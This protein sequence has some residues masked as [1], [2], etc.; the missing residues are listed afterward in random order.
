LQAILEDTIEETAA[1]YK[2][3]K[4]EV[5]ENLRTVFPK[6]MFIIERKKLT[7]FIFH[8]PCYF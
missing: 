2:L 5:K 8:N 6:A 7:F 1:A 3:E 4:D